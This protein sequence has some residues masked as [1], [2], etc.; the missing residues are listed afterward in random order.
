MS[1]LSQLLIGGIVGIGLFFPVATQAVT[2]QTCKEAS[3]TVD[4]TCS[5]EWARL[6]GSDGHACAWQGLS[7]K[8]VDTDAKVCVKTNGTSVNR[9]LTGETRPINGIFQVED[10]VTQFVRLSQWGLG[11]VAI[12][13]VL[14]FIWAGWQFLTAAGRE[15]N[16]SE[17]KRIIGGTITG[18]IISFSAYVIINFAVFALTG[19]AINS[20]DKFAGPLG[21]VFP[22]LKEE[23]PFAGDSGTVETRTNCRSSNN[24]NWDKGCSDRIYCADT[25]TGYDGPVAVLQKRLAEL[26]CGCSKPDGCYGPKTLECVRRFQAVNFLPMTGEVDSVTAN[27]LATAPVACNDST[28]TIGAE[29]LSHVP[30]TVYPPAE[31]SGDAIGTCVVNNG[32]N[33]L[34][35][36]GN[37]RE[38]SCLAQGT[39]AKFYDGVSPDG[40]AL[41]YI[42][43]FCQT[44]SI[45]VVDPS[46]F[47]CYQYATKYWCENIGK[48]SDGTVGLS[49]TQGSCQNACSN[50]GQCRNYLLVQPR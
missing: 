9:C 8:C 34:Y 18:L 23:K 32:L 5:Y 48:G 21:V 15:G 29:I 28:A 50:N 40:G 19:K 12:L 11:F 31:A 7:L 43:G 17:G 27:K 41:R 30:P 3:I 42:C 47:N 24:E 36:L 4:N 1:S 39:A 6:D 2:Y 45:A 37:V 10:A 26:G 35:C 20:T 22:G 33:D 16:I 13:A 38:T 14:M 44:K 46:L 25:G 49:F